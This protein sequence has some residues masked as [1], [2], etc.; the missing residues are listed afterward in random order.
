MAMQL[1]VLFRIHFVSM[2]EIET[3]QKK[4]TLT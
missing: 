1:T 3:H 2:E 4:K